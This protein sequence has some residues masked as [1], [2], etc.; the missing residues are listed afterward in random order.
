MFFPSLS[1]IKY[2]GTY[3]PDYPYNFNANM[4]EFGIWSRLLSPSEI[5]QLYNN[6]SGKAYPFKG[7]QNQDNQLK[8][9]DPLLDRIQAYYPLNDTSNNIVDV[10]GNG[11]NGVNDG[12]T[13]LQAGKIGTC[14]Y[15]NDANFDN[16]YVAKGITTQTGISFTCWFN[17]G[18]DNT[19][20]NTFF[21]VNYQGRRIPFN[22]LFYGSNRIN[23]E[24]SNS[25]TGD[26]EWIQ[27]A[28]YTPPINTWVHLTIT[29]NY[30]L[31]QIIFYI[32]GGVLSLLSYP[33]IKPYPHNNSRYWIGSYSNYSYP[34]D[35][36]LDEVGIWAK[37]LTSAD[38]SRLY[39]NGDG[40]TYPFR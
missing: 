31:G 23:F 17:W 13:P 27:S 2:I 4:D 28:I 26:F 14:Y 18:G 40:L 19:H 30:N 20:F 7:V 6:G 3:G 33:R 39:N 16:I 38:I 34:F 22:W 12:A 8:L 37:A 11:R 32:N 25:V 1:R 36:Y 9:V 15:F 5:K 24:S 10:T 35:G 29:H 21:L